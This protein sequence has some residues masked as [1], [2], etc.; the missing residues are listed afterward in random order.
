MVDYTPQSSHFRGGKLVDASP[1]ITTELNTEL[2][3][4][5]KQYGGDG[6]TDMTKFPDFSK[7]AEPKIDAIN[8]D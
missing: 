7:F 8:A 6:K 3:K 1:E 5:A 4:L 2:D